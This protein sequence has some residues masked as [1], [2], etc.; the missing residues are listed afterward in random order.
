VRDVEQ[1][2]RQGATSLQCAHVD[3]SRRP[4][5]TLEAKGY[6]ATEDDAAALRR[7]AAGSEGPVEL[8]LEVN[9]W[10]LCEIRN[11]AEATPDGLKVTLERLDVG[12]VAPMKANADGPR[13]TDGEEFRLRLSA[14]P[15]YAYLQVFY[16]SAD[17][18]ANEIYRGPNPANTGAGA[19]LVLGRGGSRAGPKGLNA[20][21][22][23]F[24]HEAVVVVGA[25]DGKPLWPAAAR[26]YDNDRD[27]LSRL[28]EAIWSRRDAG[29]T[30][31]RWLF[32]TTAPGG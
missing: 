20:A 21:G 24:G 5:S 7:I 27:M 19:E 23:P 22:P 17:G 18:S 12:G 15:R 29:A 25:E 6:V 26:P 10:P 14:A 4:D 31:V 9:P 16:V 2:L 1:A 30:S 13:L 11:V 8:K 3:V 32:L 28:R